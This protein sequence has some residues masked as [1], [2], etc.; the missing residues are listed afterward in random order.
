MKHFILFL[1]KIFRLDIPTIKVVEVPAEKIVYK[2]K[3]V[4]VEKLVSLDSEI[5]G[6]CT[7]KGDLI[8]E[9]VLTVTGDVSCY[10]IKG[11]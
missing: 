2:D 6:T 8:V 11:E 7:V 9:G 5:N 4:E 10:K 3:I 1:I